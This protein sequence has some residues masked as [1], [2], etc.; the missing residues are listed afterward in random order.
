M[1]AVLVKVKLS[2]NPDPTILR[3]QVVPRVK[4]LPGFVA[5]YWVRDEGIGRS[6]VIFDSEEN[7]RAASDLVPSMLPPGTTIEGNTVT[8]VVAHA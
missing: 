4:E 7:A 2:D 3:E 1:H 5:G 8:E 6:M